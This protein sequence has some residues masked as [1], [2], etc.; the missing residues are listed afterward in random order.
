[1]TAVLVFTVT[2][3]SFHKVI[4]MADELLK[5]GGQA[6][7]PDFAKFANRARMG[8]IVGS[9]LLLLVLACMVAAG[10]Y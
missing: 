9:V 2:V 10:F 8:S 3:P 4:W 5:T 6:P 7:P 1:M